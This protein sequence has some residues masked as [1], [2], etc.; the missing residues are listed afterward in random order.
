M[1]KRFLTVIMAIG[2]A[3]AV[4]LCGSGCTAES[5]TEAQHIKRV[6]K[7]AEKRY[8][9]EDSPYTSLQVFP[10]YTEN[11]EL[12]YFVI[13]F[14][15]YGY[16]Y[17]KLNERDERFIVWGVSMYTRDSRESVVWRH[18]KVA[19][20]TAQIVEIWEVDENGNYIGYR[21]S[22]YK[23]A[24]IRN[25]RRFLLQIEQEGVRC[26]IPA[27]KRSERYLNL[28]SM[29][30]IDYEA[31]VKEKICNHISFFSA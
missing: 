1:T 8:L 22:H 20:G 9:T 6:T 12:G 2:M 30:E 27:V 4:L 3:F 18:Y 14:E 26:Y 5:Y 29:E 17:I 25:E 28:V 7:L 24:D 21:D 10:L 23:V 15:P 31:V 16:V 11:D 19:T 13:E